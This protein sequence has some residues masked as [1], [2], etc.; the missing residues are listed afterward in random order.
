MADQRVTLRV[1]LDDSA[2]RAGFDRLGGKARTASSRAQQQSGR[3][4]A[5]QAGVGAAI[6]TAVVD[7]IKTNLGKIQQAAAVTANPLSTDLERGQ[8]QRRAGL[9]TGGAAAGGVA[10]GLLGGPLGVAIGASIGQVVGDTIADLFDAD[11]IGAKLAD[12][13]A[14]AEG[15]GR[16]QRAAQAGIRLTDAELDDTSR[17]ARARGEFQAEQQ[18]RFA[19]ADRRVTSAAASNESFFNGL[20]GFFD[21]VGT[22]V[23]ARIA[24]RQGF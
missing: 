6:G 9:G 7:A 20:S 21:P 24:A 3:G 12:A 23:R 11:E 16:V 10:G 5:Q 1:D 18:L 15:Q 8:A 2:A 19:E 17:G 13:I 22:S 14:K 4:T